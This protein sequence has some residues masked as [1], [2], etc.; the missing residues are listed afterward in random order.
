MATAALKYVFRILGA[1]VQFL[2]SHETVT[3]FAT[4]SAVPIT[5][6]EIGA[7][8]NIAIRPTIE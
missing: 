2:W 7:A 5:A 6:I 4:S 8:A 1:V 3:I